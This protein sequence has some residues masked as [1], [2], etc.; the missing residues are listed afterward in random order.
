MGVW[1]IR[2]VCNS[3]EV[4][5]DV[6]S[7]ETCIRDIPQLWIIEPA[8]GTLTNLLRVAV[9]WARLPFYLT[10]STLPNIE[11]HLRE[12]ALVKALRS[13]RIAVYDAWLFQQKPQLLASPWL[14]Q[15]Q[16]PREVAPVNF[17]RVSC[18]VAGRH[19]YKYGQPIELLRRRLEDSC[20]ALGLGHLQYTMK[21][22]A[23]FAALAATCLAQ[24]T[25]TIQTSLANN[26]VSPGQNFTV[27]V[28]KPVEPTPSVEVAI[29]IGLVQC[30]DN[31]CQDPSFN[32]S[33]DIGSTLYYGPYNPQYDSI[34]PPD[35][36]PP[37][38]NFTVQAPMQLVS[39]QSL[40]LSVTRLAL[41]EVHPK[42]PE[43]YLTVH[44]GE[45]ASLDTRKPSPQAAFCRPLTA[46]RKSCK[47]MQDVR[48]TPIT[49]P[50]VEVG[51]E[52]SANGHFR[53]LLVSVQALLWFDHGDTV[54]AQGHL[55]DPD[56]QSIVGSAK[57]ETLPTWTRVVR[58]FGGWPLQLIY[59]HTLEV[60]V[61][62]GSFGEN[63]RF[64][65]IGSGVNAHEYAYFFKPAV[66]QI[67]PLKTPQT[68]CG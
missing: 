43:F 4:S 6:R 63:R 67:G 16:R 40:A 23:V 15:S 49:S 62:T 55:R 24:T 8:L 38:Q 46:S 33:Q 29:V 28:T 5:T 45:G 17:D 31:N 2:I 10:V 42:Q 37:Y 11:R 35:H 60:S 58:E 25:I 44:M 59:R 57:K 32:I 26:T 27:E 48:N 68:V 61:S 22:F 52:L 66:A 30:P 14:P 53:N 65:V 41:F 18:N 64:A 54:A 47:I 21:Y 9:T 36:K 19:K 7:I 56:Q 51:D 50:E 1:G 13:A 12:Q 3:H 39:G 20:I 34:T